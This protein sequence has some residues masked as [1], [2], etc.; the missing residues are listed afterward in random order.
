MIDAKEGELSSLEKQIRGALKLFAGPNPDSSSISKVV[1]ELELE[2]AS[3]KRTK[4][5]LSNR[6][7]ELLA[8]AEAASELDLLKVLKDIRKKNDEQFLKRA[9][10][11]QR[12]RVLIDQIRIFPQTEDKNLSVHW[13]NKRVQ[14]VK[15]GVDTPPTSET[16]V[17]M[18]DVRFPNGAENRFSRNN[19]A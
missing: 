17:P 8:Q 15:L 19:F 16:S 10:I 3:I 11:A 6:C 4:E 7:E 9:K 12:I 13:A 2:A 14:E 5:N 1:G 18:F